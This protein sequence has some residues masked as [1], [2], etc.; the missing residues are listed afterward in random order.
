VNTQYPVTGSR[1]MVRPALRAAP[2]AVT[3]ASKCGCSGLSRD[4]WGMIGASIR[5]NFEDDLSEFGTFD[6]TLV[7]RLGFVKSIPSHNRNGDVAVG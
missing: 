5:S 7:G 1:Y 3:M 4:G 2:W 6:K